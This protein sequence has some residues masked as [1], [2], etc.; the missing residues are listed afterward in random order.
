KRKVKR[1]E[2]YAMYIYKVLKQVSEERSG[3]RWS[4]GQITRLRPAG[5]SGYGHF[6]QSH[7]HHELLR[8][9]PVRADRH[10]G[11]PAGSV[12]QALHHHQQRGADRGAAAAA[13]G[14]GQARSVRG[15]QSGHQ[16][17]QLQMRTGALPSRLSQYTHPWMRKQPRCYEL[18]LFVFQFCL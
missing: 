15:H 7:E 12:Q 16:V 11:V 17:H 3:G 1:R 6:E 5:S 14:A 18:Q 10:G 4:A 9:R 13:R 2:T 8:Q